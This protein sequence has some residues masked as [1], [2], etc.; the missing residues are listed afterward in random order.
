MSGRSEAE[1][2]NSTGALLAESAGPWEALALYRQRLQFARQARMWRAWLKTKGWLGRWYIKRLVSG[3][4]LPGGPRCA[5]M[6]RGEWSLPTGT[7]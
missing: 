5:F 6:G 2:L 1:A 3:G 4:T 7:E